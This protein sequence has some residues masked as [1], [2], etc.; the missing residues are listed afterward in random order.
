M[1]KH[2]IKALAQEAQRSGRQCTCGNLR[3]AAR[4]ITQIY[5]GLLR[6]TGLKAT[7]L[8]VLIS[9][10]ALGEA[11]VSQFAAAMVMDRTTLT[12]NLKPLV[13]RELMQIAPGADRRSRVVTLTT[14]GRDLLQTAWPHWSVAQDRVVAGL[15]RQ[16]WQRL[17]ADLSAVVSLLRA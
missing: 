4:A 13:A 12:R 16:R 9:A 3:Q 1:I 7:Q 2:D 8:N 11:T 5:D 6:P 15:G 14:A 17:L 10:A